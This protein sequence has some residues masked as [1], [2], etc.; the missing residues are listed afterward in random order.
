MQKLRYVKQIA[1]DPGHELSDLLI[2]IE[3]KR[4]VLI[5]FKNF[6]SHVVFNLSAH[7]MTVIADKIIAAALDQHKE[8]HDR[9]Q[10]EDRRKDQVFRH[11]Y[12][13]PGYIADD[14]RDHECRYGT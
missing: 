7:H 2:V 4:K 5:V 8:R 1:G 9:P 11:I 12:D 3:R 13:R 10:Y 14:Q 6:L